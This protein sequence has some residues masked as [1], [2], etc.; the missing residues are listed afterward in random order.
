[1]KKLLLFISILSLNLS[2]FSQTP[3]Y[4]T[5]G[6]TNRWYVSGFVIGVK[7]SGQ[8]NITDIGNPCLGYYN[9][10]KDSSY[11]GK[12]YKVFTMEQPFCVFSN[13]VPPLDKALI[14]EDSLLRKVYMVH[15]DSVNECVAMDFGM[16]IGDSIYL[17]YS[18]NSY[19]LKNGFYKLD[20][21]SSKSHIIGVRKHFYLSKF[22]APINFLTDK[23]Y[24][25]E[26][27]ESIGATHF[28]IN[29]I[30]EEQSYDYIMPYTCKTNQYSSYVTCKYTN[31]IKHYQDSCAL[32]FAQTHQGYYFFGDNCEY[33]G[34]AGHTKELS[35]IS[36]L[37]LYPNPTSTDQ[38]TLKFNA[39]YYKP[40]E[41]SIYNVLGQK[42][43][44]EMINIS[45]SINEIKLHDLKLKQG[46]YTLHMK[47]NEESSFINFIR[48]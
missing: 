24:Y 10:T 2:L 20:S 12:T 7:P 30:N 15:P 1:M 5:L 34:F 3:Y 9:A 41:I 46:L 21:I 38:L 14:R 43:F 39:V 11:N 42:V 28:P 33:Y 40:I 8:Q 6:D 35:F 37:E 32:I 48:N 13:A 44:S 23:K 17:P 36:Q 27:I 26:W 31:G 22:D 4:K 29:I 25:I 47:S 45:T 18:P 16:N 19:V